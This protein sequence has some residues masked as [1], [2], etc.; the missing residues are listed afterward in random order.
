MATARKDFFGYE[1]EITVKD[2]DADLKA[3]DVY[4]ITKK[5]VEEVEVLD[6]DILYDR[7][8]EVDFRLDLVRASHT[9]SE[10][11]NVIELE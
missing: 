3:E 4:V 5:E 2:G 7:Q 8:G 9:S 1:Y 6:A 11:R 10:L